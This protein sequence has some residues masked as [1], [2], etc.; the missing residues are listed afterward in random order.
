MLPVAD[1]LAS[2]VSKKEL[3]GAIIDVIKGM[4]GAFFY[5]SHSSQYFHSAQKT[6]RRQ[7]DIA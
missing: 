7:E 1:P 3:I 4:F 5:V 2:F 6:L